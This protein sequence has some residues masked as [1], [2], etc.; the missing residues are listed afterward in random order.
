MKKW[1]SELKEF[2][3]E[4]ICRL[5][6][7]LKFK[8]NS[9][10]LDLEIAVVGNKV[11]LIEREEVKYEDAKSYAKVSTFKKCLLKFLFVFFNFR[12]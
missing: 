12:A 5:L 7:L 1:V 8:L 2:G 3:P 9:L 6:A 11:D 4:N 10:F